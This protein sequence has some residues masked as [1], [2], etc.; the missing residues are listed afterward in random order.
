MSQPDVFASIAYYLQQH[1]WTAGKAWGRE[2]RVPAAAKARALAVPRRDAECPH[3]NPR[4]GFVLDFHL[5]ALQFTGA[6]ALAPTLIVKRSPITTG[7]G[8]AHTAKLVACGIVLNEIGRAL[9]LWTTPRTFR[10]GTRMLQ[11]T[12]QVLQVP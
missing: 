8:L 6:R 3:A 10:R 7:E 11:Q 5:R 1:G 9:R 4:A 12:R 2:V